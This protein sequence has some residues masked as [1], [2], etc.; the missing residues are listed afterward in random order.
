[1]LQTPHH[2]RHLALVAAM[3]ATAGCTSAQ[4][5]SF[6]QAGKFVNGDLDNILWYRSPLPLGAEAFVLHPLGRKFYMLACLENRGF[7]RLEVSRVRNSP[8][9]IDATG[10]VWQ[11]YPGQLRFRVTASA[12]E[13][14]FKNLD[15][16]EITEPGD[17][18][19]FLL[20]LKFRLKVYHD[21]EL[22]ILPPTSVK[23]I[24]LPADVPGEERV[25]HVSFD[26]R[27]LPV[28][29]RLVL[30]VLSPGGQLLTRFHLELL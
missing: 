6:A 12:I 17:M 23:L 15:T 29:D 8:F 25:Y 26:T 24:G 20:R 28:D 21:L 3:F 9:V 27:Q 22:T 30:E 18:N 19:S 2:L 16:S 7:D 11:H 10:K 4:V 1:M 5:N 14:V 13:D